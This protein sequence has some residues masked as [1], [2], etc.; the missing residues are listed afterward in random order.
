MRLSWRLAAV[1]LMLVTSSAQCTTM[2]APEAATKTNF[3]EWAVNI[4]VPY[5][6]EDF[7]TITNDGTSAT[8]RIT[9]ELKIKGKWTEKQTEIRCK[10]LDETWQ[11]EHAMQFQ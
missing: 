9:V 7:H 4:R 10:N 6:N 8:V 11:C 5:R 2:D 1:A 3:S